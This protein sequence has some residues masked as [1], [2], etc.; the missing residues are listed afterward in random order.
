MTRS[1]VTSFLHPKTAN[2]SD[3]G[4]KKIGLPT[5][6]FENGDHFLS[7][8]IPKNGVIDLF[9]QEYHFRASFGQILKIAYFRLI[10]GLFPIVKL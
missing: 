10:F 7:P 8:T 1:A 9:S 6:K 2:F 4:P 3:F 5:T